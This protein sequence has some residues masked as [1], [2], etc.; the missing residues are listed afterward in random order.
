MTYPSSN[1]VTLPEICH[2]GRKKLFIVFFVH[3]VKDGD[4]ILILP[5]MLCRNFLML[6]Q[7]VYVFSGKFY[8]VEI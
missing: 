7:M 3:S 1:F 4:K 5:E 2:S 6:L 8:P